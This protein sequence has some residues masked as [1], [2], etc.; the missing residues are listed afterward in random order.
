VHFADYK[1]PWQRKFPQRF[2]ADYR[3]HLS[4]TPWGLDVLPPLTLKNQIG[5][6]IRIFS[7]IALRAKLAFRPF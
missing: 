2:A 1:K 5:R 7:Q 6:V 4:K 3:E